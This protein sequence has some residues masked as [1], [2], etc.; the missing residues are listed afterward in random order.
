[1]FLVLSDG[2]FIGNS[3]PSSCE[4]WPYSF[5]KHLVALPPLFCWRFFISGI[6]IRVDSGP[7]GVS[8]VSRWCSSSP[9][10]SPPPVLGHMVGE[11][12]WWDDPG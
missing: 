3:M 6:F 10:T 1:M 9:R 4:A 7:A 11:G 5:L 8:T 12:P 2:R